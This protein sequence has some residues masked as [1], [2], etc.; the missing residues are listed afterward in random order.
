[1]TSK[2]KVLVAADMLFLL[3]LALSGST[4]GI[5][6]EIF[7]YLAFIAP[8]GMM[9]SYAYK[10]SENSHA[11]ELQA[12]KEMIGDFKGDFSLS[13]KA[14][15]LSLPIIFPAVLLILGVSLL[16]S[17]LLGAFGFENPSVPTSSFARAL[18]THALVPAFLEEL[19][20]RFAPIKLLRE[21]R[22]TALLLSS[23]M[24]AFAHA[25]LFQIPYALIAGF[26]LSAL[27]IVTGSILPS[28]ILHFINNTVSLLSIYGLGDKLILIILSSLSLVSLVFAIIG[29]K[30]LI[31]A[32]K[33]QFSG[34]KL[35]LSYHPLFFIVTSL[36]LAISSLF[37]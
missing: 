14:I 22:K 17:L 10:P 12:Q 6:S 21:N 27:Y 1:M 13:K 7:Y 29:R 35:T 36:V 25:N 34:E 32:F 9:L 33:E 24:F 5:I 18:L 23:V 15:T 20:F 30:R 31:D 37:A 26:I 8:V 3:L 19:L 4:L 16:C 11:S 2:I 28:I